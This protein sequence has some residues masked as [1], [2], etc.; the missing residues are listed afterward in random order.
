MSR[1]SAKPSIFIS[2]A[3]DDQ[4]EQATADKVQWLSF[5]IGCLQGRFPKG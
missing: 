3:H 2:Y 1:S 5:V 4:P